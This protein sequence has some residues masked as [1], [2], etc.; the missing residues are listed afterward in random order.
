MGGRTTKMILSNHNLNP[1]PNR[2]SSCST[3][4]INRYPVVEVEIR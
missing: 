3:T 2:N 1:K 4:S